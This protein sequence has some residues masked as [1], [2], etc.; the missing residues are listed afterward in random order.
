MAADT[1]FTTNFISAQIELH[2]LTTGRTVSVCVCV[3][4]CVFRLVC[5]CVFM[6]YITLSTASCSH[7]TQDAEAI[8][9]PVSQLYV[10]AFV[11]EEMVQFNLV[12]LGI[13][14]NGNN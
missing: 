5:I 6:M 4:V 13:L 2:R 12:A 14:L 10:C 11:S 3:C 9:V 7:C 1:E 8:L